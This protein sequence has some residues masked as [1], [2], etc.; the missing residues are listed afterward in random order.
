MKKKNHPDTD[1]LN[2]VLMA[3][4]FSF[5]GSLVRAWENNGWNGFLL[6]FFTALFALVALAIANRDGDA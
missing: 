2:V 1:L 6:A 5:Y 3:L 4:L